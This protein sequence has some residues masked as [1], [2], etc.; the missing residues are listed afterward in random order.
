MISDGAGGTNGAGRANPGPRSTEPQ[1]TGPAVHSQARLMAGLAGVGALALCVGLVTMPFADARP[2]IYAIVA[3]VAFLLLLASL[4]LYGGALLA[5]PGRGP[6]AA[7][8]R[9]R[10]LASRGSVLAL[11]AVAA[12]AVSLGVKMFV[13]APVQTIFVQFSDLTGRVQLE[14]CPSLPGSFEAKATA[15]DISGSSAVVPVLVSAEVCGN[16]DF[17]AGVWLHLKRSSVTIAVE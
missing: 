9:A 14:F 8:D 10:V 13:P 1:T 12:V 2:P 7:G 16:S 4:A 5:V 17:A 15:P 6:G 3:F 11:V